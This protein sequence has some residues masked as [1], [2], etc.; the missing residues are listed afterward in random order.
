M[1]TFY[2][3]YELRIYVVNLF[4]E[5]K[6]NNVETHGLLSKCSNKSENHDSYKTG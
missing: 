3:N 5:L 2:S 1:L 4:E 6:L